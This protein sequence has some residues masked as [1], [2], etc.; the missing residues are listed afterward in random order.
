MDESMTEDIPLLTFNSLYNLMRNEKRI[1]GLAEFP[2]F[3]YEALKKYFD[4]KQAEILVLKQDSL[5]KLQLK[6]E[7][8][9]VL[10][11]KKVVKE[12]IDLRCSKISN[13]SIKNSFYGDDVL[14]IEYLVGPEHTFFA[15]VKSSTSKFK[16]YF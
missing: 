6:K 16:K 2:E 11:S 9:V 1:K 13:M 5:K 8:G 15:N 12:L 14:S 3:F 7:L 4:D 10:N